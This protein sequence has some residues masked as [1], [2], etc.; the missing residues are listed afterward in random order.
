M[1]LPGILSYRVERL[2]FNATDLDLALA[3][4]ATFLLPVACWLLFDLSGALLPLI[5]YYGIF[6]VAIV[7]WRKKSLDYVKPFSWSIKLF[8]GLLVLQMVGQIAGYLTI[9]P[10]NDPWGGVLLTL[11]IWVPLNAAMEQLLWVYIFDA[12]E[13]RWTEKRKRFLGGVVGMLLAVIFVGLIHVIF[14]TKFLPSFE[15]IMPWSQLFL[16]AQFVITPGY[17]LLYRRTGSMWPVFLIHIISDAVL[18]LSAM[19]SIGPQ[20][21]TL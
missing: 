14:W 8:I 5:L 18:V 11:L 3:L 16:I 13:T 15:S 9:I 17:L 19:Y 21:W 2:R 1:G 10:V 20:L 6:C 4:I 12:F 7:L